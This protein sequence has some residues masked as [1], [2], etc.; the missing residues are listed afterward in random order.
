MS[1]TFITERDRNAIAGLFAAA[2]DKL[3][4]A[5]A[6]LDEYDS[7]VSIIHDFGW[8]QLPLSYGSSFPGFYYGP[9]GPND[10]GLCE[11]SPVV[12][13]IV[14]LE[15]PQGPLEGYKR[16]ISVSGRFKYKQDLTLY[17]QAFSSTCQ[18]CGGTG[19]EKRGPDGRTWHIDHVY[20]E[21]LGGDSDPDNLVLACATCNIRKNAKLLTEHLGALCRK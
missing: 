5:R 15:P 7:I 14:S 8:T 17:V 9:R 20:A 18:Y 6:V 2:K 1:V 13:D 11:L 21:S 19:D 3:V 10:G 12:C 4:E 16:P